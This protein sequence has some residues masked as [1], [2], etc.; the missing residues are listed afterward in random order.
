[1]TELDLS[2]LENDLRC[3]IRFEANCVACIFGRY[4]VDGRDQTV[5]A[6]ELCLW[7]DSNGTS[8]CVCQAGETSTRN[9]QNPRHSNK[10][11]E[12][13]TSEEIQPTLFKTILNPSPSRPGPTGLI[14]TQLNPIP[15][16][17][18]PPD[19]YPSANAKKARLPVG[20]LGRKVEQ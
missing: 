8:S 13:A 4:P 2:E 18:T 7:E 12:I 15:E 11:P 16:N 9:Q 19:D 3:S 6:I 10:A 14:Q 17:P 1:V 5:S 20:R